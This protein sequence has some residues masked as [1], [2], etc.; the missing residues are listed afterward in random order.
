MP[1]SGTCSNEVA[2]EMG[3]SVKMLQMHYH[4]PRTVEEGEA[5][6]AMRPEMIRFDPISNG[7]DSLAEKT[8]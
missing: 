7:S 5:W 8:A 6:F 2:G 4:N 3:T 1:S